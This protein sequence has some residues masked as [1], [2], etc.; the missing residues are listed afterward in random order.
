MAKS[1][2]L[3][4]ALAE[5]NAIR[6]DPQSDRATTVLRQLL[7]GKAAIAVANSAKLIGDAGLRDLIPDLTAAFPRFVENGAAQDPGCFAK[8]RIAEALYKLEIPSE[9]IFLTGIRHVQL[10][11]VWGG[12][13]DTACSLRNVCALGLVKSSYGDVMLELADLLADGE[14]TVRSGAIRAIAYSG[15]VEALPLLRYKVQVGDGELAVV[16]DGFAAIL[17]LD[18]DRA[19]PLVARH[20]ADPTFDNLALCE[21]AAL[22]IGEAKVAGG[23]KVLAAFWERL[24]TRQM[25][26]AE[27]NRSVLLSIAMLRSPEAIKLLKAI[28]LE[29]P[30]SEALAALEALRIYESDRNL[31][32]Q[33]EMLV[34]LRP[35]N[36]VRQ[37][38][39]GKFNN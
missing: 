27:L 24:R 26:F 8:F 25:Q 33:V 17:E 6:D 34:D 35:D 5:L 19:L 18:P 7:K 14:P 1:T 39:Q 13:E 15:R 9:D 10:E 37:A 11:P 30:V 36:E 4:Q 32:E 20:L 23:F 16:G 12:S 28:L 2:K 38:F 31:W 3:D 21:M 29:N 22:A